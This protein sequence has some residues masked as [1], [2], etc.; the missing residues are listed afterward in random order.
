MLNRVNELVGDASIATH[1]SVNSLYQSAINEVVDMLPDDELLAHSPDPI[2]LV[3]NGTWSIPGEVKILEVHSYNGASY[4]RANEVELNML[5]KAR[6]T[7]SLFAPTAN[8]PIYGITADNDHSPVLEILPVPD[9]TGAKI[10]YFKYTT[11]GEK[12]LNSTGV[13]EGDFHA[14]GSWGGLPGGNWTL[15]SQTAKHTDGDATAITYTNSGY[16]PAIENSTEYIV[17]FEIS[18]TSGGGVTFS[19]G[20]GAASA[21]QTSSGSVTVT[22]NASATTN[23]ITVTPANDFIGSLDNI[24]VRIADGSANLATDTEPAHIP[25]LAHHAVALRTAINILVAKISDAVQDDEDSE[26][27]QMLNAQLGLLQ[28]AYKTEIGRLGKGHHG[29]EE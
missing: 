17:E 25:E 16:T 27:Q 15:D 5:E 29:G 22:S 23:V 26:V 28:T 18:Y 2:T 9:G 7:N 24:K 13:Y 21:V 8:N 6:D 3:S 12:L 4:I 19:V 20:G 11:E 14:T 10:Y 1:P